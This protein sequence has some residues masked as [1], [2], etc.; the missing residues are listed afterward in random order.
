[1]KPMYYT[2]KFSQEDKIESVNLR[3]C[4][5]YPNCDKRRS[6]PPVKDKKI[7]RK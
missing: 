6:A 5:L 2:K 1:M 7:E 3:A 4:R